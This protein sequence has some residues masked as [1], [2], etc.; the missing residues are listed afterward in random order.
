MTEAAPS[1]DAVLV[2]VLKSIDAHL[3]ELVTLKQKEYERRSAAPEW[4]KAK[5]PNIWVTCRSVLLEH[6]EHNPFMDWTAARDVPAFRDKDQGN[7]TREHQWRRFLKQHAVPN[8][9][10]AE[11]GTGCYDNLVPLGEADRHGPLAVTRQDGL[12]C[13]QIAYKQPD[14]YTR[15]VESVSDSDSACYYCR[16]RMVEREIVR[17]EY[18][19]QHPEKFL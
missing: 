3:A 1:D 13:G 4:M 8:T 14:E 15:L 6:L 12:H 16:K 2:Q 7:M 9:P 19:A 5:D 10:Q 18:R 17:A 11:W